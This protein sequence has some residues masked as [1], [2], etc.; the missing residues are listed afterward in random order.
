[1]S[2]SETALKTA[3]TV[4]QSLDRSMQLQSRAQER[5]ENIASQYA[6]DK[7]DFGTVHPKL[8]PHI[9]K[10]YDDVLLARQSL[11]RNESGASARL[12]QAKQ[13]YDNEL[14]VMKARTKEYVDGR[15]AIQSGESLDTMENLDNNFDGIGS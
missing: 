1:M 3:A 10:E 13:R 4:G 8:L 11:I 14:T 12:R 15:A 5:R 2:I 6:I 7:S 9:Q